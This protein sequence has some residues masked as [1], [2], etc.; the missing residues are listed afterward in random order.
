VRQAKPETERQ[1]SAALEDRWVTSVLALDNDEREK[2]LAWVPVIKGTVEKAQKEAEKLAAKVVGVEF[3]SQIAPMDPSNENRSGAGV[4]PDLLTLSVELR[5][6]E[7]LT[8][9][10]PFTP[11]SWRFIAARPATVRQRPWMSGRIPP[12]CHSV[13]HSECD[14]PVDP[15]HVSTT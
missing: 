2:L 7:P 11:S 14:P 15:R 13:S 4:P 9:S 6:F 1:I 5:G 10:M 3:R 12:R 8:S